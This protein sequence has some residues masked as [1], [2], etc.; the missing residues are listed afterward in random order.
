MV[1]Q[2]KDLVLSLLGFEFYSLAPELQPVQPKR[3]KKKEKKCEKKKEFPSW[4]SSNEP[5]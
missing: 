5:N 1:Q 4:L 2:I 3:K